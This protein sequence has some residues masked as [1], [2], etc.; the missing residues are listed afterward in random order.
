MMIPNPVNYSV[1]LD[2][3]LCDLR[4]DA[5]FHPDD[6]VEKLAI[7]M[8]VK[9]LQ[10]IIVCRIGDRYEVVVGVGR[11]LAARKKA[12]KQIR[13]DVYEGLTELQKL[14]M[15]FAENEDR[16]NA[17]PLYQANVLNEMMKIGSLT[18][19]QL[20]EEIGKTQQ[21][22]SQYIGLMQLCP[23]ILENTNRFVKIG[24]KHFMQ[25]LRVENNDDQWKL[26]KITLDKSLSSS[27]LKG[28]VD[29]QLG[30]KPGKKAGRPKGDKNIGSDGIVFTCKG[31]NLRIKAECDISYDF[32]I[33]IEKL[34]KS[35]IAWY[36]AQYAKKTAN[37]DKPDSSTEA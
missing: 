13:A 34:K 12:W 2:I 24:L 6:E 22:V 20:A 32:D 8:E 33:F 25:L 14:D 3:N 15:I 35:F 16:Q 27:E 28:L 4:K 5:R 26:A 18:Q 19:E 11:V 21:N 1:W 36:A 10:A 23:Q 31:N 29:K 7:S 9:Q 17:S 30:V 37:A